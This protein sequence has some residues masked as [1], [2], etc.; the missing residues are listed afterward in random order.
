MMNLLTEFEKTRYRKPLIALKEDPVVEGVFAVLA[1][2]YTSLTDLIH[3]LGDIFN[4]PAELVILL[5]LAIIVD[6]VTGVMAAKKKGQYIRSAAFRQT[7]IKLIEYGLGLL[8]LAGLAN[9]MGSNNLSGWVGEALAYLK[10]IHWLGYF[11]CIFHE[12]KSA[13]I[14]NLGDRNSAIGKIIDKIDRR[15]FNKNPEDTMDKE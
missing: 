8:L 13:F 10:N 4:T 6:V 7:W 9:V 5:I 14:E 12:F 2:I 1:F 3:S 15:F 11:Y